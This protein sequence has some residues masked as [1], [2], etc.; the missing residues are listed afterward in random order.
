MG[1]NSTQGLGITVFLT[2][3][4]ALSSAMYVG[5]VALY[6]VAI[7]L[8]AVSIG[9]LRKCKPWEVSEN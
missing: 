6:L 4:T 7:A 1:A 5:K 9:I 3:F 8:I 2:A